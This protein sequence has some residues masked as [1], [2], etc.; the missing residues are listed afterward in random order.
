MLHEMV[1]GQELQE[2]VDKC[3][4]L[5]AKGAT[6]NY[7]PVLQQVQPNKLGVCIA[8]RDAPLLTAGEAD[9]LFTI[10]SIVKLMI[11]AQCLL[12]QGIDAVSA[13]VSVEP[14][15]DGFNDITSLETKNKNKPLNPMINAGAIACI[16]MI[17]GSTAKDKTQRILDLVRRMAG[18]EDITVDRA[19]YRSEKATGSRNRALAYYMQSTGILAQSE[20]VEEILDAYFQ[21]CSI[22]VN[23]KDLARIALVLAHNGTDPATGASRLPKQVA[24]IIKATMTMC[25][26]YNESGRVAIRIGL[27]TKSGVGGGILSVIPNQAGIGIFGPALNESGSSYAGVALLEELAARLDASIF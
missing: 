9:E 13:K 11:F 24:R 15:S 17:S 10:Q 3:R 18:R 7:I 1:T 21:T 6:A 8:Q 14:T 12:E 22:C 19:V 5:A 2:L 27:P 16:S 4:P 25:G 26:M 20:P 23:T